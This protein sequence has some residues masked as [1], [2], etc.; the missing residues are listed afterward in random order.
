[1][2]KGVERSVAGINA[3]LLPCAQ[4][5]INSV[6]TLDDKFATQTVHAGIV[7][8]LKGFSKLTKRRDQ[9]QTS[10][11]PWVCAKPPQS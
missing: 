1:M 8:A 10:S 2:T 3:T 9:N 7:T 4:Q 11:L 6:G 5:P